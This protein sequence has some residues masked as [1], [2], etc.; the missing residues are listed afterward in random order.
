MKS[1]CY[2]GIMQKK[3][4]V[5]YD[6]D[7]FF[8]FLL[9]IMDVR[10]LEMLSYVCDSIVFC[11]NKR[12]FLEPLIKMQL[13]V[14]KLIKELYIGTHFLYYNFHVFIMLED[15]KQSLWEK[16]I[17][18]LNNCVP[19]CTCASVNSRQQN[20]LYSCMRMYLSVARRYQTSAAGDVP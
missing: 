4:V 3:D 2:G 9:L 17:Y 15:I 16:L 10:F 11:C 1:L 19:L 14:L 20:M 8:Y 7:S 18:V 5:D 12:L 13:L 6:F